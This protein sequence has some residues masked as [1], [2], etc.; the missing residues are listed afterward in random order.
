MTLFNKINFDIKNLFQ[1]LFTKWNLSLNLEF[2]FSSYVYFK[3]MA[4]KI[5]LFQTDHHLLNPSFWLPLIRKVTDYIIYQ[6]IIKGQWNF[7][8]V[9]R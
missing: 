5:N 7:V 6:Y 3:R 4:F 8:D 2:Y 9:S 1:I